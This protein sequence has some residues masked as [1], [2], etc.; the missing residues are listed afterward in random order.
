MR[1][2]GV[3][4]FEWCKR[5]EYQQKQIKLFYNLSQHK[6]L[7]VLLSKVYKCYLKLNPKS[8]HFKNW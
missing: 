1:N 7:I 5:K 3:Y 8:L 2:K 4:P 6:W